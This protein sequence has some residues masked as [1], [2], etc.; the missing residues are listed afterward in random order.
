MAFSQG[1]PDQI[2]EPE[3]RIYFRKDDEPD[4]GEPAIGDESY[5]EEGN[6]KYLPPTILVPIYEYLEE[7]DRFSMSLVCKAWSQLFSYPSLWRSREFRF[8]GLRTSR[9]DSKKAIYFARR[10]GNHLKSLF[11]TCEHP[12]QAVA[13][14]FQK[15]MKELTGNLDA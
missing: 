15:T 1:I 9:C 3:R 11:I 13:K 10:F 4:Y 6:W 14:G 8:G 2:T 7:G 5:F 12:T